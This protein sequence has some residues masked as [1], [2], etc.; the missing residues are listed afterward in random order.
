MNSTDE[1]GTSF[2]CSNITDTE[3]ET[4]IPDPIQMPLVVMDAYFISAYNIYLYTMMTFGVPGNLG[5]LIV[6]FKHPPSTSTDWFIIFITFCDFTT[7][8]VHVPIYLTFS[9]RTW[10][11][12]GTRIICKM[13][14]FTSQ[15]IVLSSSFLIFGLALDRYFKICRPNTKA[16]TKQRARNFCILISC[17]MTLSSIPT[18]FMADNVNGR[19]IILASVTHVFAY[20]LMVFLSFLVATITFL[21]SYISVARAIINSEKNVRRHHEAIMMSRPPTCC[22]YWFCFKPGF[23]TNRVEPIFTSNISGSCPTRVTM[24]ITDR[25][26]NTTSSS[27]KN[28]GTSKPTLFINKWTTDFCE[29][30]NS[31]SSNYLENSKPARPKDK[32]TISTV[33]RTEDKRTVSLRTTKI[34]FLVCSIFVLTWIPPW[35][36][37]LIATSPK[38]LTQKVIIEFMMFG[39]M[40]HLL[41]TVTNPI[42]YTGLNRKFRNHAKSI[43]LC[44]S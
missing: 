43:M 39:R 15:S 32:S 23:H 20:Y 33:A 6:F 36:A 12:Y 1:P 13:H 40:T 16:F 34:A 3:A 8:L 17:V 14:F 5:V 41:N 30:S 31:S 25:P 7:A 42:L 24:E 35:V 10:L 27:N 4:C 11:V 19:C 22:V 37:F 2:P 21:V 38:L 9:N 29:N 18:F 26:F 44:K 28:T